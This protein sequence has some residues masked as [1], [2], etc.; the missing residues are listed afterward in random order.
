[1]N[2]REVGVSVWVGVCTV[3]AIDLNMSEAEV[4]DAVSACVMLW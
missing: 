3:V 4:G 1:M 2:L